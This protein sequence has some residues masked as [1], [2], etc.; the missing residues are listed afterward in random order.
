MTPFPASALKS[1]SPIQE[2]AGRGVTCAGSDAEKG[3]GTRV[4]GGEAGGTGVLVGGGIR[5]GVAVATGRG[6]GRVGVRVALAEGDGKGGVDGAVGVFRSEGEDVGVGGSSSAD[7]LGVE[8]GVGVALAVGVGV[9]VVVDVAG[10]RGAV[11][12]GLAGD[13][14][15][16][17]SCRPGPAV[18][19]AAARRAPAVGVA[20]R[21][22]TTLG[23]QETED[24]RRTAAQRARDLWSVGVT[25]VL[26]RRASYLADTSASASRSLPAGTFSS[27]VFLPEGQRTVTR[28]AAA[29]SPRPKKRER[30][31]DD[32]NE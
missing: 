13:R 20:R 14:D 3:P 5:V 30:E 19:A 32:R 31:P 2:A 21:A 23:P 15:G 28:S 4:A 18:G 27:L 24:N 25:G 9:A 6:V 7:T 1:Q 16:T 26:L 10:G 22:T 29:A 12:A 17:T 11:G 8:V